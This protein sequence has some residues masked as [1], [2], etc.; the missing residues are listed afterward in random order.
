MLL[1]HAATLAILANLVEIITLLPGA[2]IDAVVA[3]RRQLPYH[4]RD[5]L[6]FVRLARRRAG[7]CCGRPICPAGAVSS[8]RRGVTT[9]ST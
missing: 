2:E 5:R 4:W 9:N 6:S 8:Y 3:D 7:H 1:Q